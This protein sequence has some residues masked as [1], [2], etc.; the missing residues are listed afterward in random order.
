VSAL[1]MEFC[2]SL[3]IIILFGSQR[4]ITNHQ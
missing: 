1:M 2:N 4:T 3:R